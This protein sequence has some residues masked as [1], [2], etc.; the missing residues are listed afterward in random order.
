MVLLFFFDDDSIA[1]TLALLEPLG[2]VIGCGWTKQVCL[3]VKTYPSATQ[4]GALLTDVSKP[5]R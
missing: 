2:L 1:M 5:S 4:R 3:I